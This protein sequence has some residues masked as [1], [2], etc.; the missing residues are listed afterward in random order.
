MSVGG[1]KIPLKCSIVT[2]THVAEQHYCS[3]KNGAAPC[4]DA[5][6]TPSNAIGE[7]AKERAE[8]LQKQAE[9]TPPRAQRDK[10]LRRARQADIVAHMQDWLTSPGLQSPK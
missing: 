6:R 1:S 5:F 2:R 10:L 4:N 8:Y 3:T 9:A 7:R